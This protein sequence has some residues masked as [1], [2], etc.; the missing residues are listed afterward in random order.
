MAHIFA[1]LMVKGKSV[2]RYYNN[3]QRYKGKIKENQHPNRA[4][5]FIYN[6]CVCMLA[7]NHAIYF[8][9]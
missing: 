2:T 3:A 4:I 7:N 8:R 1:I 9:E 5:I 6:V